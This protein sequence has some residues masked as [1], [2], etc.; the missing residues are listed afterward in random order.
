MLYCY[1]GHE[2]FKKGITLYLNTYK[3]NNTVT[4]DLWEAIE[5]SSGNPI[6]TFMNQY[7]KQTGYPLLTIT[8]EKDG[9]FS[10]T[11]KRYLRQANTKL[12]KYIKIIIEKNGIYH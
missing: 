6:S 8:P 3:Y 2:E 9:T 12:E 11:Q 10:F 1:L 4:T 5:K 7:V